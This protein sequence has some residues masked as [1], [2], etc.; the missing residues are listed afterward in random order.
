MREGLFNEDD[1]AQLEHGYSVSDTEENNGGGLLS[2]MY[3][4]DILSFRSGQSMPGA[5]GDAKL[6]AGG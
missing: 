4:A 1:L 6:F 2:G 5:P 3:E